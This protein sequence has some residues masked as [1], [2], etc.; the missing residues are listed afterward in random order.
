MSVRQVSQS[1]RVGGY[2]SHAGVVDASVRMC[3]H[4]VIISTFY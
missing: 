4:N 2:L 3:Y 1:V